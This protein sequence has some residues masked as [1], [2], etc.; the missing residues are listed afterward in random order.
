MKLSYGKKFGTDAYSC[1]KLI[2]RVIQSCFNV[3]FFQLCSPFCFLFQLS[4]VQQETVKHPMKFREVR[5]RACGQMVE[6]FPLVSTILRTHKH[7]C[8]HSYDGHMQ[9]DMKFYC[10]R[11]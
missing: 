6:L 3:H 4:F 5:E 2:L 7:T 11:L 1:F 10:T 8:A 9:T